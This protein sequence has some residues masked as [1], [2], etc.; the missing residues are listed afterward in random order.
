MISFLKAIHGKTNKVIIIIIIIIVSSP[1]E[2]Q[3]YNN[4]LLLPRH[5]S[6]KLD[7]NYP[8]GLVIQAIKFKP[9]LVRRDML[10][11][12]LKSTGKQYS[13]SSTFK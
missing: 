11:Q 2:T 12:L 13:S 5:L 9:P 3:P 7:V 1:F 10:F 4:K 8:G 6:S